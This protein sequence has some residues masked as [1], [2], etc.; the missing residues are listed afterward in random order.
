MDEYHRLF[1]A[2][3]WRNQTL[4]LLSTETDFRVVALLS[5]C[6]RA[7]IYLYIFPVARDLLRGAFAWMRREIGQ[8]DL[9]IERDGHSR[10]LRSKFTGAPGP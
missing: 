4:E 3:D 5:A 2:K 8:R 7:V 6:N 1:Q 9:T 10:K